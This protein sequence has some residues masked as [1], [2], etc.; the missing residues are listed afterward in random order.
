MVPG[1]FLF[2]IVACACM[3]QTCINSR[4]WKQEYLDEC[5]SEQHKQLK[6]SK[7]PTHKEVLL[8]YLAN[9]NHLK[10]ETFP[11]VTEK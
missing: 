1:H 2:T 7:L 6:G 5:P 11:D 10:L 3:I 8:S 4:K 9:V